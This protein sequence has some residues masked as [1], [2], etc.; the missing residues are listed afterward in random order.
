M[1]LHQKTDGI[2]KSLIKGKD[3][4]LFN[5]V[6]NFLESRGLEYMLTGSAMKNALRGMPRQYRD[7]DILVPFTDSDEFR[8][9]YTDMAK[10]FD[11]ID[12][13]GGFLGRSIVSYEDRS[14]QYVDTHVNHR[15]K[16]R[17]GSTEVDLSFQSYVN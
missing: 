8:N 7:I 15:F 11:G 1:E 16:L 6:T 10:S 12:S 14:R 17:D 9:A 4:K 13:Y 2:D 5:A 3:L